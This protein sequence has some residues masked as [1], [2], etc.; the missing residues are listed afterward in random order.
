MSVWRVSEVK[1]GHPHPPIVDAMGPSLSQR[2]R[3]EFP[4][5]LGEG[6]SRAAAEG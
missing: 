3:R 2:E 1:S 6:G 4:L 5:P